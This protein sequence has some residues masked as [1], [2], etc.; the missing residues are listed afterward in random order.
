MLRIFSQFSLPPG[1]ATTS[2]LFPFRQ[3]CRL[4]FTRLIPGTEVTTTE[5]HSDER[6]ASLDSAFSLLW[7]LC[8]LSPE[9]ARRSTVT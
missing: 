3:H 5:H 9:Y 1:R 2:R 4:R 6:S 8:S 7:N